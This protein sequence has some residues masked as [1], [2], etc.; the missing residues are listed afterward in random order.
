MAVTQIDNGPEAT[1]PL[2]LGLAMGSNE[3]SVSGWS[4][5]HRAPIPF[6]TEPKSR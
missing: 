2:C 3:R 4:A 6:S 1:V 5:S